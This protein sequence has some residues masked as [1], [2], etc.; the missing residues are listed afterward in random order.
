MDLG[1]GTLGQ[2]FL[3]SL[4][5]SQGLYFVKVLVMEEAS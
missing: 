3:L 1:L 4:R 2:G 5:W